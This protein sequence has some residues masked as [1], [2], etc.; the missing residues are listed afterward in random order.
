MTSFKRIAAADAHTLLESGN[1]QV[2]DIRDPGS[3]AQ[4]HIRQALYVDNSNVQQFVEN[5]DPEKP[6]IVCCY[7]GNSSQGAA[8][9]F[10]EQGFKD[11]YSL[12]GGYEM[13]KMAYPQWCEQ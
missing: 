10:A 12:D 7:H 5:A 2:I 9:Y 4:G 6:L 3:Y 13:W 8:Q 11:V 1:T